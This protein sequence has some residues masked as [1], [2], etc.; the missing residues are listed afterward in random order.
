[1]ERK[2]FICR[3]REIEKLLGYTSEWK[4]SVLFERLENTNYSTEEKVG[5]I[6]YC[7]GWNGHNRTISNIFTQSKEYQTLIFNSG[8]QFIEQFDNLIFPCKSRSSKSG[9]HVWITFSWNPVIT[10]GVSTHFGEQVMSMGIERY[11]DG[12]EDDNIADCWEDI[13]ISP[14]NLNFDE[15]NLYLGE[16]GKV[17]WFCYDGDSL[18]VAADN[19]LEFFSIRF[20]FI[21]DKHRYDFRTTW[22]VED[23]KAMRD[24]QK[25]SKS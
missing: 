19:L 2:N 13:T 4:P 23:L 8:K 22:T 12:Y 10:V 3:F 24:Y 5:F 1:M 15:V 6:L 20:S 11:F 7:Y 9:S 14:D 16:S 18:G 17:Y 25:A 21:E